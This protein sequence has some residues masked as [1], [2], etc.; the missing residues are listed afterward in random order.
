MAFAKKS[1][2]LLSALGGIKRA[3]VIDGC[4]YGPCLRHFCAPRQGPSSGINSG[5]IKMNQAYG[6]CKKWYEVVVY[7]GGIRRAG[8]A[9]GCFYGLWLRHFCAPQQ[10][11]VSG[12]NSGGVKMN[13][14]YGLCKKGYEVSVLIQR[15]MFHQQANMHQLT[16]RPAL[17]IRSKRQR[18][19]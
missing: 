3:G 2:R 4:F 5:G 12:I 13:Q 17:T 7:I 19:A 16:R 11:S 14:A 15:H 1:M 9:D 8:V 6:L 10:V 18:L